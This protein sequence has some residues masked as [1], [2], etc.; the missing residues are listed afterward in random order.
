M[1]DLIYAKTASTDDCCDWTDVIIWRMN[2]GARARSC[3]VYVPCPRPVPVPGLTPR[4]IVKQNVEQTVASSACLGKTHYGIVITSKGEKTVQ[5]RETATVWTAGRSEN[6]DKL[7]G[8]RIGN[9]GRCRLLLGSIKP[10]VLTNLAENKGVT[11]EL[12]AQKLV[13]L[14][15]GKTLSSHGV[16]AAIKKYHPD[17]KINLDQLNKRI[18]SLV[19]SKFVGIECHDDTPITH[20]SLIS[21]DPR[22][23]VLSE[24]NMRA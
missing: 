8:K 15:K 18:K 6:Y 20:Y 23:Y 4:I 21:V 12:S 7:T 19:Q 16:L 11:E 1:T 13:A 5:L 22:F 24:S 17:I 14:M 3:S 10:M 2:A 9:N